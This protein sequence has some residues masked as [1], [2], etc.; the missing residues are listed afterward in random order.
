M[1]TFAYFHNKWEIIIVFELSEVIFLNIFSG[2][3]DDIVTTTTVT[4]MYQL[5]SKD[6][7]YVQFKAE[8]NHGES[9]IVSNMFKTIHFLGQRISD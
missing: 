3:D 2:T 8:K 1:R 9:K 4:T 5:E 6:V 7:I